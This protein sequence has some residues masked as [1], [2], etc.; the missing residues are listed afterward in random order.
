MYTYENKHICTFRAVRTRLQKQMWALSAPTG[1]GLKRQPHQPQDFKNFCNTHTIHI[2]IC[3]Y[4]YTYVNM[5]LT[6]GLKAYSI[7]IY[8]YIHMSRTYLRAFGAPGAR[9]LT[10]LKCLVSV[11]GV[12][13]DRTLELAESKRTQELEWSYHGLS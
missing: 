4:I 3:I 11:L 1:K 6:L 8:M 5:L 12:P 13:L 9:G 2:Y 10:N 7:Y